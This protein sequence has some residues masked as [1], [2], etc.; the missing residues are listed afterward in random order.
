V[1]LQK[2]HQEGDVEAEQY[3]VLEVARV[4]EGCRQQRNAEK[5]SGDGSSIVL[6]VPATLPPIVLLL[7]PM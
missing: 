1:S 3:G 7:V 5:V 2:I 4:V 6:S